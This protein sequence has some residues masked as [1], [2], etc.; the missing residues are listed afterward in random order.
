MN[1]SK[2]KK[3][4]KEYGKKTLQPF[5]YTTAVLVLF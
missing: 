1:Y 3:F 2:G 5:S 4:E